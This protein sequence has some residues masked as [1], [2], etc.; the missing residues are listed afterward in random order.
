[1]N[2]ENI[3]QELKELP[4]WVMWKLETREGKETK[5]PYQPTGQ[6]AKSTDPQ[7]WHTLE[8][9]LKST[10]SFNGV[11]FVFSDGDPYAGVDWDDV[12]DPKTGE[13]LPGIFE[14]ITGLVSYAEVSQSG[15]GAHA[16]VRADKPGSKCKKKDRNGT[17]EREMYDR[18][19]FFVM[20]GDHI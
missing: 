5:I 8:D 6:K 1:M 3:P 12:R 16:I 2:I 18:G 17:I 14:E 19:R 15:T 13:Y 20:T 9:C 4:Q 10:D 7:T 11:G